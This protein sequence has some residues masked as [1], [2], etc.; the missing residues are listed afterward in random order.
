MKNRTRS[1]QKI[2]LV[3]RIVASMVNLIA[4]KCTNGVQ[5]GPPTQRDDFTAIRVEITHRDG[6]TKVP[7]GV[8]IAGYTGRTDI[9]DLGGLPRAPNF[10]TPFAKYRHRCSPLKKSLATS[11]L[12]LTVGVNSRTMNLDEP[13]ESGLLI[14]RGYGSSSTTAAMLRVRPALAGQYLLLD[15]E[16]TGSRARLSTRRAT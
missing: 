3:R 9:L 15:D 8:P 7:S 13:R 1:C 16:D 5:R 12:D 14:S 11:K 6:G 4:G 2:L 10:G